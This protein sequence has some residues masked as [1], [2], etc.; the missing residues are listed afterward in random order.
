MRFRCFFLAVVAAAWTVTVVLGMHVAGENTVKVLSFN[1]RYDTPADGKNR[2]SLRREMV[3][4]LIK[5]VGADFVGIQEATPGQL[6]YLTEQLPEYGVLT[7]TREANHRKGEAVPLLFRRSRWKLDTKE[8]GT[9]WLSES[10]EVPGSRSWKTACPRIV[11]W[12]RFVEKESGRAVYVYN[13]HLDHRSAQARRE[14]ARLLAKRIAERRHPDPVLLTGDFNAGESSEPIRC[15]KGELDGSPVTL[16]DTFRAV[17]AEVEDAGT[18]H[19]FTGKTSA[20]KIDYVFVSLGVRVRSAAILH[21]NIDG[22]YPSDH[23]PVE[24]EVVLPTNRP[25]P[26]KAEGGAAAKA[27]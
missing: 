2:W 19:G 10:P 15:L 9:F 22:R 6:A 25:E 7:R 20:A 24:A 13:T 26:R 12:G 5:Q 8:Q 1:I 14:G 23:C 17:H 4:D 21:N 16:R 18:F 27:L 3:R 11:T